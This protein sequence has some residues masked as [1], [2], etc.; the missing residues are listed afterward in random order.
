MSV[1]DVFADEIMIEN[2]LEASVVVCEEGRLWTRIS[3]GL[4]DLYVN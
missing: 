4:N 1:G 2:T 3:R